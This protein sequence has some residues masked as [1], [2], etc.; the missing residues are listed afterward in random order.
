[1]T[2]DEY[3][4]LKQKY[5]KAGFENMTDAEMNEFARY[6]NTFSK[7][8][9]TV[10]LFGGDAFNPK[11]RMFYRMKHIRQADRSQIVSVKSGLNGVDGRVHG[12]NKGEL[13]II[14]GTNGSGKSTWLSQITLEAATQ[15]F[16]SVIFS[17]ELRAP[18]V[19]EWLMLQAAGRDNLVQDGWMYHVES[20]AREKIE[21]WM[22]EKIYVYNNDFGL[23][24][25]QIMKAL[26]Y[27]TLIMDVDVIVLD[28]LMSMD[29][30][31][32]PGDKYEKQTALT[33]ELS[34]FAKKRNVHI[35]FVCHPR[36][37][38]GLLR[39]E[40]ISGTADIT[41]AADNVLIVHR[42]NNDF[43]N[44]TMDFFKWKADA[45]IY[46]C[47]NVVE[48]CKNRDLGVQDVFAESYFDQ[49]SKLFLNYRDEYRHYGWEPETQKY[50]GRTPFDHSKHDTGSKTEEPAAHE[51]TGQAVFSEPALEEIY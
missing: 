26:E 11:P 16:G 10:P 18:Q 47:S 23:A 43:K 51:E 13:S 49:P 33:M 5:A 34:N 25:K 35:F 14:S 20:A 1:M 42:V 7:L 8:L 22:D 3:F 40:D 31:E 41:N 27:F 50:E 15:G 48:I 19:K 44:R 2:R 38:M 6:S 12:F 46:N 24:V 32:Y 45:A 36:K 28:N 39:K 21:N 29:L 9:D 37:S 30:R 17:G 4:Q